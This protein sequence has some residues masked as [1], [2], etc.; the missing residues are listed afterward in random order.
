[1]SLTVLS[2]AYP[3]AVVGPEAV[4]GA[5]QVL[6]AIDAGLVAAG[7]RSI[8]VA[9][10]GSRVEG[11]LIPIASDFDVI[12]DAARARAHDQL[13][14]AIRRATSEHTIDLIHL[15]G[16]DFAE[17]LPR[18]AEIPKLVTL[19]LPRAW[20]P[21][22]SWTRRKDL[23]FNCVSATQEREFRALVDLVPIVPNGVPIE[24][25]QARHA[26]RGFALMLSRICPEKGIHLGLEAARRAGISCLVAGQVFPYE[27]HQRYFRE[28][29]ASRLGRG[30]RFIGAL[31]S[32]RKRRF[33]SAA[34]CVLIPSLAPETASLVAME[35]A[36]CGTPAI[37][38]PN[39]ALAETIEHGR[40]GLI[41]RGVD[42]MAEAV[43][44]S[45][46][47]D[48]EVCRETARRRF[49][50]HRMVEDYLAIYDR[51]RSPP[52]RRTAA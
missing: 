39:G 35:A 17:Y 13:R 11:E 41:V 24:A 52:R 30:A 6:A 34:R 27:A 47:I 28:E 12:D 18:L 25:L 14:R 23:A 19:H 5:E 44:R 50:A 7:H 51:L 46:D 3:F 31:H 32:A 9:Q 36:A 40:T 10:A 21:G 22:G 42:E 8:V 43:L 2:V 33:L 38:F 45:A 37:S 49:S 48:P 4:G 20:Y 26:R 1:M 29:I 16:V 15:H